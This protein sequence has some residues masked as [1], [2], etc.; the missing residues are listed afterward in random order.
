VTVEQQIKDLIRRDDER[1]ADNKETLSRQDITLEK[2]LTQTTRTNGRVNDLESWKDRIMGAW[3]AITL[4]GCA[5]AWILGKFA[6]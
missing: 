5:G 4:L 1:H 6:K 2:I 3:F